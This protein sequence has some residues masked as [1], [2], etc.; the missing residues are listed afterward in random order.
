MDKQQLSVL[1]R[2]LPQLSPE[3]RAALDSA[4][5]LQELTD[6][7]CQ[8]APG[9]APGV[10]G[11]PAEFFRKFW[12]CI[13]QDLYEVVM[14]CAAKGELPQ[15]CRRAVLTLLPKKGELSMIKNWRPVALLCTDFKIISKALA[16]RFKINF[17]NFTWCIRTFNSRA[18]YQIVRLETICF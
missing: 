5:S 6:A 15:S 2:G 9:R 1:H 18:V 10:D 8:M 17:R 16:N 11:L 4:L 13:G 7:V 12:A 3:D 14:K